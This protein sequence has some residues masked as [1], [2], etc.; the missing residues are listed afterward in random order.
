MDLDAIKQRFVSAPRIE[1]PFPVMVDN[2]ASIVYSEEYLFSAMEF[3]R[4]RKGVRVMEQTE[5]VS[6]SNTKKGVLLTIR[7]GETQKEIR[8]EKVALSCGKWI[9]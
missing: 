3:L 7:Q 4:A 9:G 2:A 1:S 8:C 5:L 6:L